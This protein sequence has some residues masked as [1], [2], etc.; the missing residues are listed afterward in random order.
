MTLCSLNIDFRLLFN[1]FKKGC[2][3]LI[4]LGP[5]NNLTDVDSLISSKFFPNKL[6]NLFLSD[7][8]FKIKH[9]VDYLAAAQEHKLEVSLR[10]TLKV[11]K[12]E[13]RKQE[14]DFIFKFNHF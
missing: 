8:L 13:Y 1:Q 12:V 11:V 5:L 3:K 14:F 2:D 9:F 6:F 4:V 7:L 10:Q